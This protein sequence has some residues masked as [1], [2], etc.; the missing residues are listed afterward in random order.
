[1]FGTFRLLLAYLVVLSHLPGSADLKPLGFF[2]VRSFFVVS[3][4]VITT[5]LHETY[6]FDAR[7][8]FANRVLRLLPPYY[9]VGVITIMLIAWQPQAAAIFHQSWAEP[10]VT[11]LILNALVIPLD[12]K[13]VSFRVSVPMWSVAVELLMYMTLW[14]YVA[15][16]ARNAWIGLALGVGYHLACVV[17]GLGW[18]YRYFPFPAA[19]LGFSI[20]AVIYFGRR[21]DGWQVGRRWIAPLLLAFLTNMA[22]AALVLPQSYD[23][24]FGYYLAVFLAA[25]LVCALSDLNGSSRWR[26]LDRRL[27]E[28]AYPVF[29]LQWLVAFAVWLAIPTPGIRGWTLTLLATPA[30][31][32]A[33]ALLAALN[34][35]VVDPL[36]A[37]IRE[38]QE[39][40]LSRALAPL[41]KMRKAAQGR[42]ASAA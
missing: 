13:Q 6:S 16:S 29:L 17:L 24:G 2:A 26:S 21:D 18:G 10:N 19:M 23:E 35:S 20:G 28:L 30:I 27:G 25:L 7:R 42:T 14:V 41:V 11:D 15:R 38:G 9:L 33:A 32:G 1:M 5:A 31:F 34:R 37:A 3:G 8:F 40:I 4:F 36:R 22:L 39:P 12:F